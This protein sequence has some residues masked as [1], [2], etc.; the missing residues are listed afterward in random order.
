MKEK[1][2]H[3]YDEEF[4]NRERI[5]KKRLERS[6]EEVELDCVEQVIRRRKARNERDEEQQAQ[7]RLKAKEGMQDFR[8]D[9]RIMSL[10]ERFYHK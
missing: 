4:E 3:A 9:G 7:E 6:I 10:K 1:R 2:L 8:T 5:K